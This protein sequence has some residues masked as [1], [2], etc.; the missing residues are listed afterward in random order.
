MAAETFPGI[1]ESYQ[2]VAR[3]AQEALRAGLLTQDQMAAIINRLKAKTRKS[4]LDT[5]NEFTTVLR[6]N[7]ETIQSRL[8]AAEQAG[9]EREIHLHSARLLDLLDRAAIH[10][11]DTSGWVQPGVL[12][13][14]A[15][16]CAWPS[17]Q[18]PIPS[19]MPNSVASR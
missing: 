8:R 7:I 4:E 18:L 19:A 12:A 9:L 16:N 6:E 1:V 2:H 17:S 3:G 10:G 5:M 11:I 14:A 13:V 15:G